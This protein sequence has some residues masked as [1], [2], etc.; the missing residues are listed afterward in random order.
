AW[1]KSLGGLTYPLA[2]DFYPHGKVAEAYGVLRTGPPIPGISDRA[3]FIIDKE[4]RV[5][6]AKTYELSVIPDNAEL[7]EAL[8]KLHRRDHP[9]AAPA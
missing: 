5:A 6:F 7:F 9:A 4:G 1:Q 2:S 3:V 8:D